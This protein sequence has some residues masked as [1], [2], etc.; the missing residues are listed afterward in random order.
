MSIMIYYY[1][2]LLKLEF[3]GIVGKAYTLIKSNCNDR[4]QRVLMDNWHYYSIS[5]N[6]VKVTHGIPQDSILTP[7]CFL[8][9]TNDLPKIIRDVS[10]PFLISD[11]ANILISKPSPTEFINN[12]NWVFVNI[13]D[14]LNINLLL[15]NF[16]N[17]CNVQCRTE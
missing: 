5:S 11:D 17:I 10:Q 8:L 9:Y 1:V 14:W 12:F 4:Y 6:W 2:L 3:Y 15:L 7:L 16:D 13:N